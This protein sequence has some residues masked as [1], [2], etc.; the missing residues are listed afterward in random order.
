MI[1]RGEMRYITIVTIVSYHM[2]INLESYGFPVR[3]YKH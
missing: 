1:E 2:E 3:G